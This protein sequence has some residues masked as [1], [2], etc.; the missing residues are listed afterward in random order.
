MRLLLNQGL[1][2]LCFFDVSLFLLVF[3][4]HSPS[5]SHA[6]SRKAH[7]ALFILVGSAAALHSFE[8]LEVAQPRR[9]TVCYRAEVSFEEP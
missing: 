4:I 7:T 1:F 8:L 2:Y 6:R 3:A 9:C 5:R